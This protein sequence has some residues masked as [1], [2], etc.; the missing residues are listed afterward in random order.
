[1]FE[2]YDLDQFGKKMKTIRASLGYSQSFVAESIGINVDTLRKLENGYTIPRYDTLVYLSQFYK[3]DI[4]KLFNTYNKNKFIFEFYNKLDFL[5]LRGKFDDIKKLH[6]DFISSINSSGKINLINPSI[7]K[8]ID[9]LLHA[10]SCRYQG[11]IDLALETI[12]C[13]IKLTIPD[14]DIV[15]FASFR[16]TSFEI[17]LLLVAA[18][19]LGDLRQCKLSIQISEYILTIITSTLYSDKIEDL[20][21]I[22]SLSHISYNYHRLDEHDKA[23]EYAQKGIEISLAKGHFDLLHFLFLRKAVAEM[24]LQIDSNI[25]SFKKCLYVLKISG[26]DV[27]YNHMLEL[28]KNKYELDFSNL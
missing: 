19:C 13:A 6:D 3:T 27:H 8:Q 22:K 9:G 12:I 16:Y 18:T 2:S 20:Y 28:I 25:E 1:M 5:M 21:V 17:R 26:D 24:E 4:H 15:N 7:F 11:D 10:T 23:L 14:F